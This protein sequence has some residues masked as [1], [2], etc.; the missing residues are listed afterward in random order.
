MFR[1]ASDRATRSRR[2]PQRHRACRCAWGSRHVRGWSRPATYLRPGPRFPLYNV[3]GV[4]DWPPSVLASS[5]SRADRRRGKEPVCGRRGATR[6]THL[7]TS[8]PIPAS[9]SAASFHPPY[10]Q[11]GPGIG[12]VIR[13]WRKRV[14]RSDIV[15][16]RVVRVS[17]L[18]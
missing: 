2:R 12:T 5:M 9:P 14:R 1:R 13:S 3:A 18:V 15:R 10:A 7:R 6:T 11:Y 17:A 4:T 8:I 16:C